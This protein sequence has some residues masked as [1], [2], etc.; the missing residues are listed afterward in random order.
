MHGGRLVNNQLSGASGSQIELIDFLFR[1]SNCLY[2]FNSYLVG[3]AAGFELRIKLIVDISARWSSYLFRSRRARPADDGLH[4]LKYTQ[5]SPLLYFLSACK[6]S[7]V[8][9]CSSGGSGVLSV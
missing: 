9:V 7:L 8:L 2:R 1:P 6:T 5:A 4:L 3:L